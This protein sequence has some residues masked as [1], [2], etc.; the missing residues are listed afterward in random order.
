MS[1]TITVKGYDANNNYLGVLDSEN[2]DSYTPGEVAAGYANGAPPSMAAPLHKHVMAFNWGGLMS[3]SGSSNPWYNY[4]DGPAPGGPPYNTWYE[5]LLRHP[6]SYFTKELWDFMRLPGLEIEVKAAGPW[7]DSFSFS[8]GSSSFTHYANRFR[9]KNTDTGEYWDWGS[10]KNFDYGMANGQWSS[11]I[12]FGSEA[13]LEPATFDPTNQFYEDVRV[14]LKTIANGGG[15]FTSYGDPQQSQW[16]PQL[17]TTFGGLG[18]SGQIAYGGTYNSGTNTFN[19]LAPSMSSYLAQDPNYGGTLPITY[20]DMWSSAQAIAS[21]AVLEGIPAHATSTYRSTRGFPYEL[22][23][24]YPNLTNMPTSSLPLR[25]GHAWH[26]SYVAY[27]S[28]G[29]VYA[30]NEP[31]NPNLSEFF[32][33]DSTQYIN[34]GDDAAPQLGV[35]SVKGPDPSLI[36]EHASSGHHGTHGVPINNDFHAYTQGSVSA[37]LVPLVGEYWYR[38]SGSFSDV[39]RNAPSTYIC[40]HVPPYFT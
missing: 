33:E 4:G 7:T 32:T 11:F 26:R 14:G 21:A 5:F 20:A 36:V 25:P 24:F 28:V 9:L 13:S 22:T 15:A 12:P 18:E 30:T 8:N 39:R 17:F 10:Q 23:A 35:K 1:P 29:T 34:P 3:G 6:N 2:I 40:G 31:P 19:V 16:T 38:P 37:W 27:L